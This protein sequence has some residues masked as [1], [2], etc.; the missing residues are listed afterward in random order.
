MTTLYK[1]LS[2][3]LVFS[4]MVF[5]ALLGSGFQ[6]RTFHF[7]WV[8]ELPLASAT[9]TL[10]RLTACR[11]CLDLM[12]MVAGPGYIALAR[13]A[14]KT[15]LSTALLLLCVCCGHHVTAIEPL[16]SNGHVYRTVP[17]KR[18]SADF[19]YATVAFLLRP[20]SLL[21][22]RSFMNSWHNIVPVP[23]FP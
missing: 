11:L 15:P 9:A 4:V 2:H 20:T 8:P 18:L 21:E 14:Y 19:P 23:H 12:V 7:L 1:S 3:R 17:Q 6:W 22:F 13:T 16:H 10:N 5:T